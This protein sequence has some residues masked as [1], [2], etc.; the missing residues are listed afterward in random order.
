MGYKILSDLFIAN[1]IPYIYTILPNDQSQYTL[2]FG[3]CLRQGLVEEIWPVSEDERQ[4]P[5]L[6]CFF[7][8][9]PVGSSQLWTF[10]DIS[11]RTE[12]KSQNLAT[13][14][15][16]S[17]KF[18]TFNRWG[19]RSWVSAWRG[20]SRHVYLGTMAMDPYRYHKN[21]HILGMDGHKTQQFSN[22]RAGFGELTNMMFWNVQVCHVWQTLTRPPKGG[23]GHSGE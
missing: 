15:I 8:A 16:S 13:P 19:K 6:S 4:A 17:R 5:W 21:I 23:R 20:A 2:G 10:L 3:P 14:A 11:D 22:K 18:L 9:S 12:K 7:S 1:I